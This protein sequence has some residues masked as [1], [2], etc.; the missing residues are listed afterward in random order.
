[1]SISLKADESSE[2]CRQSRY[3]ALTWT[4]RWGLPYK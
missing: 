1:V 4:S 3:F 2:G